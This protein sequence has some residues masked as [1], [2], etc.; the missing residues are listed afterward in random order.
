MSTAE[1]TDH[2]WLSKLREHPRVV[3]KRLNR[4]TEHNGY[5][6]NHVAHA[7]DIARYKILYM[8]GGVHYDLDTAS[9]RSME[10]YLD[11]DIL[12]VPFESK[13]RPMNSIVFSPAKCSMWMEM[14]NRYAAHKFVPEV[15]S[16]DDK[17][18]KRA[19]SKR[20]RRGYLGS[21]YDMADLLQ[22]IPYVR[23]EKGVA[24]CTLMI[25]GML[26]F[27]KASDENRS[28]VHTFGF[29]SKINRKGV[30][31]HFKRG[32]PGFDFLRGTNETI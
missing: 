15:Y 11:D 14:V 25:W 13:V 21:M 24:G 12:H 23:M 1:V 17:K 8:F 31:N 19:C 10:K 2:E 28:S 18:E 7:S 4:V 27:L 20:N 16:G 26:D 22:N 6:V 5:P 30:L 3:F 29:S 9:Y 32:N